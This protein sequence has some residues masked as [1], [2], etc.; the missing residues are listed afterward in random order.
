MAQYALFLALAPLALV[1]A[2]LANALPRLVHSYH[3]F[4]W[5]RIYNHLQ[6][7]FLACNLTEFLSKD[8]AMKQALAAI[9]YLFLGTGAAVWLFF[10]LE[11]AG[12][13]RHP[14]PWQGLCVVIPALSCALGLAN[15]SSGLVWRDLRFVDRGWVLAMESGGYGPAAIA[16]MIQAYALTFAGAI[17]LLQ[18]SIQTHKL[19]RRQTS[20]M[21]AG[22]VLPV[23]T[24]LVFILKLVP[25]WNKDFSAP[26]AA[27]G[28]FCFSIGCLRYRLFSVVPVSRQTLFQHL[29]L[30]LLVIDSAGSI[31][32][33][34]AAACRMIG[35]SEIQLLGIPAEPVLGGLAERCVVTRHQMPGPEGQTEAWHI[36]LR[37]RDAARE[38]SAP[39][40]EEADAILSLGELRVLEMLARNLSN[41]EIAQRL[42][43]SISTVKFHL[44]NAFRKTGAAN[45]ADLVHRSADILNGRAAE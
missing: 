11:Y 45:R 13:L 22:V 41:K 2:L 31:V 12:I 32:D 33:L 6:L 15:G 39:S 8:P 7:G 27:L 25:G 30:G 23:A 36:E 35:K 20:W 21:L 37:E 1:G 19:F 24:N 17:I 14:K 5:L 43:V 44:S 4:A 18:H 3:R 42:G 34:N 29:N 38:L 28:G 40:P 10:C 26:M 9:D 16:T